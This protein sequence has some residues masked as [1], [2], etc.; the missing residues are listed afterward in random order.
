MW[1]FNIFFC[2]AP[3]QSFYVL[4]YTILA[5]V[6]EP[7]L[8]LLLV[9]NIPYFLLCLILG[10]FACLLQFQL[11]FFCCVVIF[12]FYL[13]LPCSCFIT[14]LVREFQNVCYF[15][16][17]FFRVVA[18]VCEFVRLSRCRGGWKYCLIMVFIIIRFLFSLSL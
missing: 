14:S 10:C 16:V 3:F 9:G 8:F 5:F 17:F 7:L 15:F 2:F 1:Y 12:F 6:S 11:Y 4:K 13:L 18:E